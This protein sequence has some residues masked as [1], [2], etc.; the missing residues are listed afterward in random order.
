MQKMFSKENVN[1]T[2]NA[3]GKVI[4]FLAIPTIIISSEFEIEKYAKINLFG[5]KVLNQRSY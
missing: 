2:K 5:V 3:S 4:A 1:I